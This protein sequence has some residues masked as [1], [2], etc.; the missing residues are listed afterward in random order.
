M[1]DSND[2]DVTPAIAKTRRTGQSES[3]ILKTAVRKIAAAQP[4][5]MTTIPSPT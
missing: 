2:G 5:L 1:A 3:A 4:W